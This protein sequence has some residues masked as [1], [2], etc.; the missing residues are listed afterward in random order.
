[1]DILPAHGTVGSMTNHALSSQWPS[2]LVGIHDAPI[3]LAV[4]P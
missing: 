2:R 1:M 3:E 4:R